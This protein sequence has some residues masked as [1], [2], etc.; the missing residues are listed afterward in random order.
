MKYEQLRYIACVVLLLLL[1]TL[2]V[3][4]SNI[5]YDH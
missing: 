1:A 2:L 4:A 3:V 5:F